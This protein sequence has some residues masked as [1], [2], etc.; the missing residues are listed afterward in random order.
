MDDALE[1]Y[2]EFLR[3][4]MHAIQQVCEESATTTVSEKTWPLDTDPLKKYFVAGSTWLK[5]LELLSSVSTEPNS[6]SV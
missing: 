3:F 6:C 5:Y 1:L 4:L 2:G